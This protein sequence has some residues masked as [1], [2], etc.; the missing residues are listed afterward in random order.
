MKLHKISLCNLNS[1]YGE[2]EID[3]QNDLH[4]APLFLIVGQTGSGKSTVLDAICLALF[5]QTPRLPRSPGKADTAPGLIMSHGTGSCEARVEFS[6]RE[7]DGMRR[8]YRVAW[9]CRR[10]RNRP[11][12]KLQP[13][14]RSLTLVH[15]EGY[16]E[17]IISDHRIKKT[18]PDFDRVLE[19]LSVE[20]FQRSVLLAQGQFSAFLKADA[21][22]KASI[23]ERL[24][25]TDEYKEIGSRAAQRYKAV[26]KDYEALQQQLGGLELLS[27]EDETQLRDEFSEQR[28]IVAQVKKQLED[29]QT[30]AKWLQERKTFEENWKRAE[31]K[32][33]Q[34]EEEWAHRQ[35]DL[36]RLRV[37][38]RCQPA[39]PMLIKVRTL[40]KELQDLEQDA[41]ALTVRCEEAEKE[42]QLCTANFDIAKEAMTS[43]QQ[44]MEEARPTLD[45][46]HKRA[47]ALEEKRS[48]LIE[49]QKK[50]KKQRT[51]LRKKQKT[52][53]MLE[54]KSA[55]VQEDLVTKQAAFEQVQHLSRLGEVV[56]VLEAETHH[57]LEQ[58]HDV[59]KAVKR[60]TKEQGKLATLQKKLSKLQ[61]DREALRASFAPQESV[62]KE[63]VKE[64]NEA[65]GE[66][67]DVRAFRAKQQVRREELLSLQRA[68]GEAILQQESLVELLQKINEEERGEATKR[69]ELEEKQG[70]REQVKVAHLEKLALQE[71]QTAA[72]QVLERALALTELRPTL[73]DG[74]PCPLC[75]ST[76]HPYHEGLDEAEA[77]FLADRD[78][79]LKRKKQVK[80]ECTGLQKKLSQLDKEIVRWEE[81]IAHHRKA[82]EALQESFVQG[83]RA[84]MDALTR[85]SCEPPGTFPKSVKK[86]K[87]LSKQWVQ[88]RSEYVKAVE[89]VE[90]S[91]D[92]V[93]DLHKAVE[94][95]NSALEQARQDDASLEIEEA[96]LID[97]VQL[98]QTNMEE[99]EIS[100]AEQR[101]R[102]REQALSLKEKFVQL[103]VDVAETSDDDRLE[104]FDF[105]A[106]LETAQSKKQSYVSAKEEYAEAQKKVQECMTEL[107]DLRKACEEMQR[108]LALLHEDIE[109]VG[110]EIELLEKE[111]EDLLRGETLKALQERLELAIAVAK[112]DEEK[113]RRARESSQEKHHNLQAEWNERQR[114]LASRRDD[115]KEAEES[116]Q[117]ALRSLGLETK[118]E[119]EGCL[120]EPEIYRDLHQSLNELKQSLEQVKLQV[121]DRKGALT[122]H[123]SQRPDICTIEDY[124]LEEWSEQADAYKKNVDEESE[125]IGVLRERIKQMEEAQKKASGLREKLEETTQIRTIW[126]SINSLI[127][128]G[129]GNSF[130]LFAQSLNLQELV[131]RANDRL[132]RLAPR[133]RLAVAKGESGQPLLD[134]VVK[135]Q[136]QAD[137]ER[138]IT[139]LSGGETFLV[140]LA[141]ALALADFRRIKMPI[142]TLLLDEGFGTL[143]QDT[144][145]VVMQ[146]LRQ[147]QQETDQQIALI[148]HVEALK[149][150]IDAQVIIEKIGNGRSTIRVSA[151]TI[152]SMEQ[153]G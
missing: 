62:Q 12:G 92:L 63:A 10:S 113:Q 112:K 14:E 135:D 58:S 66:A 129:D 48:S 141:L 110:N 74:K 136:E 69:K 33:K 28:A 45:E 13:P 118:E 87:A 147:L 149:E 131:V 18:Q 21:S 56:L 35:E 7:A 108:I 26:N 137:D 91:L 38:E 67:E 11:N 71:E 53:E 107:H 132:R 117:E 41:P 5:G 17:L 86:Q 29:A 104:S 47:G 19:G 15:D 124:S 153:P 140:S 77:G 134:F 81:S 96:K 151:P 30:V 123:A 88:K 59:E 3:L 75:G 49:W 73:E 8:T 98:Q 133:Y 61:S 27:V 2:H 94:D 128:V 103:G 6:K 90:V 85:A 32:K 25:N 138:P 44:S 100:L 54:K 80:K 70:E 83:E 24:T 57:I 82:Q 97:K 111:Q 4:H 89:V 145:D 55:V 22:E 116:L 150:R 127:G 76:E 139:T 52:A 142:E 46:A 60:Q 130:K 51:A 79:L 148:S 39:A 34:Q 115:L 109:L 20:D 105:S 146:T 95:A 9:S 68:I 65:L 64:L 40:E 120:L 114:A 101:E 122:S 23:L 37:H 143:D 125:K 121:E 43:A 72:L 84:W 99:G 36:E 50:E 126:K 106:A 93:E 102:Q 42:F 16:E 1:L 144:L 78:A 119:L 31:A 152:Q